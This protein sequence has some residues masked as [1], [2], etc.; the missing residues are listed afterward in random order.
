MRRPLLLISLTLLLTGILL[1]SLPLRAALLLTGGSTTFSSARWISPRLLEIRDI[2]YLDALRIEALTVRF[3]PRMLIGRIP[4]VRVYAA[5]AWLS[6]LS[7]P[8][9]GRSPGRFPFP[10]TL[11]KLL[12]ADSTLVVDN[13][14]PGLPYAPLQLGDPTPLLF[15]GVR[16]G[17]RL[18]GDAAEE[19]QSAS[20]EHLVFYSPYEIGRAHV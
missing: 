15:T 20:T 13:L 6:R 19:H 7:Q 17:A 12:I 2:R 8:P 10:L 1:P 4:E 9:S 5:R 11:E 18:P 14:G 3:S 16:L